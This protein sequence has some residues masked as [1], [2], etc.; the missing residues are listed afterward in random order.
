MSNEELVSKDLAIKHYNGKWQHAKEYVKKYQT[1]NDEFNYWMNVRQIY[2]ELGG[3]YIHQLKL[4]Q[5]YQYA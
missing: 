3:E 4:S 5:R 1:S 2:L